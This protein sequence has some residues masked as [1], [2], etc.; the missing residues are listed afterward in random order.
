MLNRYFKAFILIGWEMFINTQAKLNLGIMYTLLGQFDKCKEVVDSRWLILYVSIYMFSIWDSFRV[1]V[2]INKQYRL[3]DWED[4]PILNMKY[5]SWDVNYL[6][7]RDPLTALLWSVLAPG[8]G[9]LYVHNI[10]SG[11]YIF[12]STIGLMYFSHIPQAV[13]FTMIG[14]FER[15]KQV[16]DMQWALYLPSMYLFF[17]YD[18]YNSAVEYN[19]LFEIEQVRYLRSKYQS[20][21]FRMPIQDR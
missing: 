4:A 19:K 1:T 6:D 11:F 2:D 13:N 5:S 15:A 8:L 14:E 12:G 18:A 9:H 21:N 10:I 16:I 7:K 3:A 17:L 20:P